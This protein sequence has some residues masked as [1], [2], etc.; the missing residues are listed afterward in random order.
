MHS[1][2][3]DNNN[4]LKMKAELR[5]QFRGRILAYIYQVLGSIISRKKRD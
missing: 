4:T 2:N 1:Y 5:V 3:N